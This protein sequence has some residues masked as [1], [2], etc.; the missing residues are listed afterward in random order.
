MKFSTVF[1]WNKTCSIRAMSSAMTLKT[2]PGVLDDLET[3]AAVLD[4]GRSNAAQS[5]QHASTDVLTGSWQPSCSSDWDWGRPCAYQPGSATEPRLGKAVPHLLPPCLSLCKHRC[6]CGG[7]WAYSTCVQV[8]AKASSL[9]LLRLELHS[10]VKLPPRHTHTLGC[11]EPILGPLEEQQVFIT[12]E[13]SL[14]ALNSSA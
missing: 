5:P 2:L 11:W 1:I 6:M 13:P 3:L 10:V 12:A 14:Q 9:Q 7:L 4:D 8:P